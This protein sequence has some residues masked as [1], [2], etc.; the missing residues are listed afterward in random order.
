MRVA[1][2]NKKKKSYTS[3]RKKELRGFLSPRMEEAEEGF[4]Y[5]VRSCRVGEEGRLFFP[6]AILQLMIYRVRVGA[7]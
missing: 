1:K 4:V 6:A 3:S 2:K 7:R 5:L